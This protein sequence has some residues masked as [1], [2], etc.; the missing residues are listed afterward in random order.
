LEEPWYGVIRC[1]GRR[2]SSERNDIRVD[3]SQTVSRI[4]VLLGKQKGHGCFR[5]IT[6]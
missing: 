2:R 6:V 3:E 5:G 4:I 1:G